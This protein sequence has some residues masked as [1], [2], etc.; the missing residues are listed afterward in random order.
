MAAGVCWNAGNV[1]CILAVTD[2]HVGMAV[3]MP[4]MQAR[5][6]CRGTYGRRPAGKGPLACARVLAPAACTSAAASTTAPSARPAQAGLFV[7]GCWGI[8]LHREIRG[9]IALALWGCSGAALVAGAALLAD[10]KGGD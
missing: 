10:A 2:P 7:A 3:A 4:I 5:G 1:C 6:A 9:T 8:A